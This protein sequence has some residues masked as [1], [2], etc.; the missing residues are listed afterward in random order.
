MK[1]S[2]ER[3]VGL[4]SM[5]WV[6]TAMPSIQLAVLAAALTQE[7]ITSES[8]ELFLDYAARI[9]LDLY[10]TLS[11]SGGMVEEWLFAQHYFGPET[12]DTLAEFRN[13]CRVPRLR[14]RLGSDVSK[15]QIFDALFPVTA[16]FLQELVTEIDWSR[17]DILGFSLTAWQ[18][19]PSMALARLIK[20]QYP[21]ITIVFGGS[22]CAGPM[23]SAIMRICP[24]A[25]LVVRVEG[26]PVLPELVRR[27]RNHQNLDD[28]PGTSWRDDDGNVVNNPKGLLHTD[29]NNRPHLRFDAYFD[30]LERLGIREQVN[31]WLPFESSRGCWYGQK[32][33][34]TFCGVQD[35]EYRCSEW[36][37]VLAELEDWYQSYGIKQFFATDLIIPRDFFNTL[38]PEIA[39]RG[40]DWLFYYEVRADLKRTQVE[41]LATAGVRWILAGIE[42]LD[43][44]ILELMKKGVSPLQNIQ[45][46][47]WSEEMSICVMW[48]FIF[49]FPGESAAAYTRIAEQIPLL[50]HLM[51]PMGGGPFLLHRFS[52]YFDHPE[53]FGIEKLGPYPFYKYV[54]PVSAADLED[55]A[56][57]HRYT[58]KDSMSPSRVYMQPVE[59]AVRDWKAARKRGAV[60]A[61][62]SS[63][64]GGIEIVD[65]RILPETLY[66]LTSD[67]ACL[68]R[69]LESAR[70]EETLVTSFHR[71]HPT[72]AQS[73][74][75]KGGIETLLDDWRR[76]GLVISDHGRVLALAVN[77][78]E[79]SKYQPDDAAEACLPF[80]YA[81]EGSVDISLSRSSIAQHIHRAAPQK[82]GCYPDKAT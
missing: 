35:I 54:F 30:R 52:L 73:L 63:R 59:Q 33:Q 37:H 76:S 11:M 81:G 19:G 29:T 77:A 74:V 71:A 66:R 14:L 4:I 53:R 38:L 78:S 50:F 55:L 8:H 36:Q 61:F 39:R 25:D 62:Y 7:G 32:T 15:E 68:Y 3:L 2:N 60:L 69:F 82:G 51:P 80:P 45:L 44:E 40:H 48:N 18:L 58:V 6:S 75:E 26:E 23:G 47:K 20:K 34:C 16:N 27:I 24:Y 41:A 5:P 21:G 43:Q 9:G 67:E 12:G 1:T 28:L 17:Y 72:E 46:L 42:S 57:F 79:I 10:D 64:D 22:Q 70:L 49:G 31:I 56:Y 13:Q 65:T